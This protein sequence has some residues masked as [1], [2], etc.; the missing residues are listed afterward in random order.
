MYHNTLIA[1]NIKINIETM[2]YFTR[3]QYVLVSNTPK[4]VLYIMTCNELVYNHT[5][6][7]KS[8]L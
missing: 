3:I 7:C 5:P 2:S 4:H 1:I 8:H 6:S